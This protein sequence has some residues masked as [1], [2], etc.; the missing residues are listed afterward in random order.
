[1]R[2]QYTTSS[3]IVTDTWIG[4]GD[5]SEVIQ[6]YTAREVADVFASLK[7]IRYGVYLHDNANNAAID[8]ETILQ[9]FCTMVLSVAAAPGTP[10]TSLW[11]DAET[12]EF[13]LVGCTFNID[14]YYQSGITFLRKVHVNL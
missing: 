7:D 10:C 6:A 4:A 12:G 2:L 1:M 11:R 9:E 5:L 14:D 13:Y 8:I 3:G